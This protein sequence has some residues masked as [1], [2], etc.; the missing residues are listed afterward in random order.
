MT[1]TSDT[2][3]TYAIDPS[4]SSAEFIV[5]HM[6][7]SKVRGRFGKFSGTLSIPSSAQVPEQIAVEIDAASIDTR[8]DQ[9]DAHL[10]SADFLHT[11][12]HPTITFTSTRINGSA[13]SFTVIGNLTIHGVTKSVEID[14][15][16]DGEGKDPWGNERIAFSGETKINRKDFGLTYN[17]VLETGGVLVGEEVKIELSV[18]AVRQA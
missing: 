9:R 1:T 10:K 6:V 15:T 14:A 7:I 18:E 2:L 13:P 4:H 3:A 5:R 11:E 17:Q 8:E 16:F 12:K